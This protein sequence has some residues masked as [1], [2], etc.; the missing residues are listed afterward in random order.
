MITI[1]GAS[2]LLVIPVRN[3]AKGSVWMIFSFSSG[4]LIDLAFFFVLNLLPGCLLWIIKFS[5][6]VLCTSIF[7]DF[8][9]NK[10]ELCLFLGVG[11]TLAIV[12]CHMLWQITPS[13]IHVVFY[14]LQMVA[15][16]CKFFFL[17]NLHFLLNHH[18]IVVVF[19][20]F[21]H[22]FLLYL[23]HCLFAQKV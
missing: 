12:S 19:D 15:K 6:G 3:N 9:L 21:F 10:D 11:H 14:A 7:N 23:F 4:R 1:K 2:L 13:L 20:F 18:F 16:L 17:H 22:F 5:S 8:R